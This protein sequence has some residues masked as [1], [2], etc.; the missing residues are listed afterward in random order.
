MA[1]V[2]TKVGSQYEFVGPV[3][4]R[5]AVRSPPC[6]GLVIAGLFHEVGWSECAL[7]TVH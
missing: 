5:L 1:D 6:L 7:L 4:V 3:E 2:L